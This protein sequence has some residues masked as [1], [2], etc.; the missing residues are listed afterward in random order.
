MLRA[1]GNLSLNKI[2]HS[3]IQAEASKLIK[4]SQ[5]TCDF[6]RTFMMYRGFGK[7]PTLQFYWLVF[8][9]T[10]SIYTNQIIFQI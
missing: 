3:F 4:F 7:L 1:F 8:N 6:T 9:R 2:F 5:K 10:L